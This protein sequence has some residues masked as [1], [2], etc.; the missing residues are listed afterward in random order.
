MVDQNS[1]AETLVTRITTPEGCALVQKTQFEYTT[2]QHA[3]QLELVQNQE[4]LY[5]AV[6]VPKEG[7]LVV[8]GS[9][10]VPNAQ[11]AIQSVID[12]ITRSGF[13]APEED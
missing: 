6:A 1:V 12:K 11:G 8:Y 9:S 4:G 7:K 10:I 2:P 5:F 3:Y 13:D